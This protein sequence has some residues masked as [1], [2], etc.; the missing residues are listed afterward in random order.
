MLDLPLFG[1]SKSSGGCSA[2]PLPT[3]T[4]RRRLPKWLKRPLPSAEM[5]FTSGVIDDLRLET[6][7]ES[8]KCPNRTECWSQRTATFM[9][10]GNVCTRP[11]GFCSVQKGKTEAIEADEPDRVAEAARRLGLKHVVI[12]C[13]TRDDLPDGGAEHFYRCVTAVREKTGAAVEVLTS[14]F[15]GN[16]AAISRVIAARP[17]VFNHNT[18]TIPRL[19]HRVRRNAEYQR[20]LDLLAQVKDEA[21]DMPTKSGLMLGLGETLDEVLDTAADL[22]GVGV[23]MLTIGQYLQP[24]PD[25]L[26]VER[27]IPPEEFDEIGRLCRGMGFSMVASGPF[28]RSSYHAGEMADALVV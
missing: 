10:L 25:Q 16:R 28:V 13:V 12:T 5:S 23:D 14:D 6:V 24:T 19:Y 1:E 20:T 17:D 15:K 21:P 8:A 22:R 26:P 27:F 11:C 2:P 4:E 3:E 9:I 7:C 18:E